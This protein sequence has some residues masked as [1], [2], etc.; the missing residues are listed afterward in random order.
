MAKSIQPNTW[1]ALMASE[2]SDWL[3]EAKQILL[4]KKVIFTG[5][6]VVALGI[7]LHSAYSKEQAMQDE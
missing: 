3:T 6:E 2:V 5:A 4:E 1:E 7:Y